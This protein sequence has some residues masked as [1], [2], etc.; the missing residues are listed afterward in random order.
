MN[1]CILGKEGFTVGWA[2]REICLE[3][4]RHPHPFPA[5][6]TSPALS[7]TKVGGPGT[8]RDKTV[9]TPRFSPELGPYLLWWGSPSG[10][11]TTSVQL[12][13]AVC[14]PLQGREGWSV[15]AGHTDLSS[16]CA[17]PQA[18]FRPCCSRAGMK[19]CS[20]LCKGNLSLPA[21]L[22]WHLQSPRG[23]DLWHMSREGKL[24]S[25][26]LRPPKQ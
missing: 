6:P 23:G 17:A 19:S 26:H 12:L 24:V 3:G 15:R 2:C 4:G 8:Q 20:A 1:L 10:E 14:C 18:W 7:S 22:G 5:L 25:L 9:I 21:G 16:L 13:T 11:G